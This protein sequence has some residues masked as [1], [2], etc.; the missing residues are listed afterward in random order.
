MSRFLHDLP[1]AAKVALAPLLAIACLVAVSAVGRLSNQASSAAL[2]SLSQE[3]LPRIE[4]V[5]K[6]KTRV[7]QLD[8]MVMRSLAYEGSGMKAARVEAVDKAIVEEL[9]AV[10]A[11]V[12]QLM[13]AAPPQERVLYEQLQKSL[14]GFAK[15]ALDTLDMKSSGLSQA[16]MLMTS[17]EQ[18]HARLAEAVEKLVATVNGRIQA[19]VEQANATAARADSVTLALLLGALLVSGAITWLCIRLIV[20]PLQGA[21]HLARDIAAGDLTRR[22][23]HTSRDET[24]QVLDAMQDVA[25]RLRG[26]IGQ[27]QTAAQHIEGA[28]TEITQ[29]NQ[30]LSI[31]TEQTAS[32]LQQ[33]ASTMEHLAGQMLDSSQGAA[34][35]HQLA[36]RAA[37]IARQGGGAVKEAVR[38]MEQ[39][40]AQAVR[41][42]DIVGVID[43]LSFQ[44]NILALNAAVEAARAGEHGRGFAV[45]AEEVRAL[46]GRSAASSKEIRALIGDSVDQAD[47]GSQK[48]QA[49]GQIMGE[50]VRA[51]EDASGLITTIARTSQEQAGGVASVSEAVS[52]MDSNTQQNAALVEQAAAATESLQEQARAL[53]HSLAVFR[54]A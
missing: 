21:V 2:R 10:Q 6:L 14:A 52:R 16:A 1:I 48:A 26:L 24:G 50:I 9:K 25:Q 12:D 20:R 36:A 19:E 54:T 43:S 34:Q 5:A 23:E 11:H 7:V 35:A 40:A 22:V 45:V 39:I 38:S 18:E 4:V 33:T 41:I 28:S 51:I 44:T 3:Q 42:R 32:E 49:A 17:A 47:T 29:G 53:M 27:I 37:D 13:Q 8:G 15:L 31:R 30:N 46:A